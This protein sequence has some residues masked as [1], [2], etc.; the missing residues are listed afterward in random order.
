MLNIIVWMEASIDIHVCV[1]I[2]RLSRNG[3]KFMAMIEISYGAFIYL[4]PWNNF[5][6][7]EEHR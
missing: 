1:D 6:G 2:N 3:S 4:F 7:R 5:L